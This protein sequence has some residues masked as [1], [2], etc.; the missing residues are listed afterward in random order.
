M[1]W[2]WDK[3]SLRKKSLT[4]TAEILMGA[5]KILCL[6]TSYPLDAGSSSGVFV[7]HLAGELNKSHDVVV[8]TP[9]HESL[10]G[11]IPTPLALHAFR[12][13]PARWQ[14]LCHAPGGIPA[15]LR[16]SRL[17]LLL[18]PFL[19]AAMLAKTFW[20]ARKVDIIQA[21][22]A[23]CGAI[24]AIAGLVNDCTVVTTL[25]GDDVNSAQASFISRLF[26]KVAIAGSAALVTVSEGLKQQLVQQ[27]GV[28]ADKI[29]VIPNGV[30]DSFL[31]IGK[32]K[33]YSGDSHDL[34]MIT[35]GSLIP[36]KNVEFLL[37]ALPA[38]PA[39]CRLTVV[40]EGQLDSELHALAQAL[41]IS[42]RVTFKGKTAPADIPDLLASHDI[43]VLASVSEGRSNALYEAMAAGLAAIAS[44]IPGTR[45][46]IENELNGYLFDLNSTQGFIDIVTRLNSDRQAL[47]A[48]GRRAHQWILDNKLS[49]AS[50]PERYTELFVVTRQG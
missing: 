37:R 28:S 3:L 46:Q 13:A 26:L 29:V 42:N 6:T 16:A 12:Y 24:A 7:A 44:D 30:A 20:Y 40:G 9:A 35:V 27:L 31:T 10:W 14:T 1:R 50:T 25:R 11:T 22:W 33:F 17:L 45:E 34:S 2:F 39:A 15:A 4:V 36:R 18:V 5:L 43:F 32:S 38:L 19:L 23:V 47:M 41:N 49:W 21:N 48:T 8:L